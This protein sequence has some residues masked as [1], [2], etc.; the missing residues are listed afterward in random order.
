MNDH[1]EKTGS[2]ADYPLRQ[3]YF[4]L[5]EGCNLR[6]RHCWIA[7]KYQSKDKTHS[8]L[9][10]ELFCSIIGQARALGL[11]GVKLTGG[12]PFLHPEI[13]RMIEYIRAEELRLTIETNGVL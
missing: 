8:S 1:Q 13:H 10:F 9:D 7:P 11:K 6:C 4:Y 2:V 12:E 5:T 3:I